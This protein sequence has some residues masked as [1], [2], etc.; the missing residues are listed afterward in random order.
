[1]LSGQH[2]VWGRSAVHAHARVNRS[3]LSWVKIYLK[4][5]CEG[6]GHKR[7]FRNTDK[8]HLYKLTLMSLFQPLGIG[9]I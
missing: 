8:N 6:Y 3:I 2:A 9:I 5:K 1:M 4:N 7:H